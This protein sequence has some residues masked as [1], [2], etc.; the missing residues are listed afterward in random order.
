[1]FRAEWVILKTWLCRVQQKRPMKHKSKTILN[2]HQSM[3]FVCVCNQLLFQHVAHRRSITL[4]ISY[5]SGVHYKGPYN[6]T[7]EHTCQWLSD[8]QLAKT[9]SK[10][11][12]LDSQFTTLLEM[13]LEAR[14]L[15]QKAVHDSSANIH[16]LWSAVM[17]L[18]FLAARNKVSPMWVSRK[19]ST[20]F[21]WG[22]V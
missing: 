13:V 8:L 10:T 11:R 18:F 3:V 16:T 20:Q 9:G 14:Y 6:T 4:L 7:S 17:V 22:P 12:R 2:H 15:K 1:M 5:V 21:L 19:R